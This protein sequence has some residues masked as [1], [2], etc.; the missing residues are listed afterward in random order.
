MVHGSGI[1]FAASG[2]FMVVV[3]KCACES[4][5]VA[6]HCFHKAWFNVIQNPKARRRAKLAF[7][8]IDVEVSTS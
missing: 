4:T 1:C 3:S 7:L 8:F 2:F 5:L 6:Y